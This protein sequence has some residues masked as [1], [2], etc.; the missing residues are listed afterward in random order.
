MS[1][2]VQILPDEL[3]QMPP[4]IAV[5]AE[6]DAHDNGDHGAEIHLPPPSIAPLFVGLGVTFALVGLLAPVVG[7][8]GVVILAVSGLRLA[9]FPEVDLHSVYL[10]QLNNR[11][12]GMWAFL[13]SE[14]MFFTSLIGTFIKFKG[15]HPEAFAAAHEVLSLPLATI[16]TTVLIISSFA[17]VMALEAIQSDDRR[18]F[19]NWMGITIAFGVMFLGIQAFEW[20]ELFH[21]GIEAGDI[22][23]TVFFTTTGFHGLHV[24]LGVVWMVLLMIRAVRGEYSS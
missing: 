24:L 1:T 6:F 14:V 2:D 5:E 4:E 7:V 8:I 11:K 12:L 3:A 9:R 18:V 19:L 20:Y 16:G 17:V 22:F 21:D 10:P 23:G 15:E 13:A